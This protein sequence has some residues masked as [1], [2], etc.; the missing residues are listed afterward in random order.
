MFQARLPGQDF[1]SHV[2]FMTARAAWVEREA[3]D[4]IEQA[5][6]VEFA[7]LTADGTEVADPTIALEGTA[8]LDVAQITQ[9]GLPLEA[10]VADADD[11]RAAVPLD[12]GENLL[13]IEGLDEAG[14]VVG[15]AALTVTRLP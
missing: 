7:V 8:W 15:A 11:L 10:D 9:G 4:S 1:A 5:V 14:E 6:P 13:L 12:L 3:P 2:A